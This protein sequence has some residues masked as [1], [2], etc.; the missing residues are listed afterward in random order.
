MARYID[1]DIYAFGSSVGYL[2]SHSDIVSSL[3]SKI[4]FEILD[5]GA[6]QH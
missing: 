2:F 3:R 4:L 6:S 1:D 5:A